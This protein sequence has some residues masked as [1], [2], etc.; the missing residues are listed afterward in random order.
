LP[1]DDSTSRPPFRISRKGTM[2]PPQPWRGGCGG[3]LPGVGTSTFYS[4]P[5]EEKRARASST[6]LIPA[7]RFQVTTRILTSS[8]LHSLSHPGSI[9]A[10]RKSALLSLHFSDEEVEAQSFKDILQLPRGKT[11]GPKPRMVLH[12]SP[13]ATPPPQGTFSSLAAMLNYLLFHWFKTLV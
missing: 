13:R 2:T 10:S 5:C 7:I 3:P 9:D 1:G 8:A 12:L 4:P 11:R 6:G